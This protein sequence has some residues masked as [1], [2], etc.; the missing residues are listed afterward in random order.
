MPHLANY[1][2]I[3]GGRG[4]EL[5]ECSLAPTTITSPSSALP[6]SPP[7]AERNSNSLLAVAGQVRSLTRVISGGLQWQIEAPRPIL[8]S[9]ISIPRCCNSIASSKR[10]P[11]SR[12]SCHRLSNNNCSRCR[13]F[14]RASQ[15]LCRCRIM[16]DCGNRCSS[17]LSS[18]TWLLGWRLVNRCVELGLCCEKTCLRDS[19]SVRCVFSRM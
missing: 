6:Q 2:I 8:P 1:I 11:I 17:S 15:V 18:E 10:K 19:L 3:T 5:C 7:P 9:K 12:I 4:K 13:I 16:R 14:S